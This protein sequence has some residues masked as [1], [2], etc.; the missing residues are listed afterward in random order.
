[1][2]PEKERFSIQTCIRCVMD[3]TDPQIRF[4]EAGVC[5]HCHEYNDTIQKWDLPSLIAN[6]ALEKSFARIKE[7]GKG[8]DFDCII[9]LS[10]GVDSSYI[11]L[12]AKQYNLRPLCVHLDNGWNSE[13]AVANIHSIVSKLEFDLHTH[14]IDW[15]DFKN[16]INEW[17]RK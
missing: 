17:R 10:G 15:N 16:E 1:M 13:L 12:L 14:V 8:K 11:A 7:E 2:E 4:D 3:T 6:N 9:G 5:N